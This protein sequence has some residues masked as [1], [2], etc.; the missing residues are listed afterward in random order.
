MVLVVIGLMSLARKVRR[1]KLRLEALQMQHLQSQTD[2]NE[3]R[4]QQEHTYSMLRDYV[5]HV[6]LGVINAGGYIDPTLPP[7]TPEEQGIV[8]YLQMSNRAQQRS[9][10]EALSGDAATVRL[11]SGE[12]VEIPVEYLIE[13][14]SIRAKID[15]MPRDSPEREPEPHG[16]AVSEEPEGEVHERPMTSPLRAESEETEEASRNAD[17][18]VS[19]TAEVPHIDNE[20]ETNEEKTLSRQIFGRN[21][22]FSQ[23]PMRAM[24]R[25][26]LEMNQLQNHMESAQRAGDRN[27]ISQIQRAM[28]NVIPFMDAEEEGWVTS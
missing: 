5:D 13:S 19:D 7:L 10:E 21:P 18:E 1:L 9:E 23:L 4:V 6:H 14:G 12:V 25:A 20:D 22:D 27:F 26:R 2:S 3:H 17:P 28:Q 8:R 16:D 11:S 24:L 15:V